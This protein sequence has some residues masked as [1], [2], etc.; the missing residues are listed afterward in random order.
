MKIREYSEANHDDV[1]SL[2]GECGLLVP[3]ND[4]S[5]DIARKLCVDRDLFIIGVVD[6]NIVAT[7]IGGYDGHRGWISYLAVKPSEQRK[8]LGQAIM[9]AVEARLKNKG[10]PK[11]N[12]QVRNTNKDVVNFYHAIGY[13][14]DNV[15]SLGKR[16]EFDQ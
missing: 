7:V 1:I 6:N 11:I 2:W 4:P 9:K 15:I 12:L 10:C 5:K 8:G 13:G 14:D 3:Q 16:L